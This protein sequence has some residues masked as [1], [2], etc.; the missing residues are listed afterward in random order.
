MTDQE[1]L[2]HLRHIADGCSKAE[3]D[4]HIVN[5]NKD[6]IRADLR[7]LTWEAED[8]ITAIKEAH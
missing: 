6:M 8:L 2:E 7:D 4:L 3:N 1:I 5:G